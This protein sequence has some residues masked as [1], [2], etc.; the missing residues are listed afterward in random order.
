MVEIDYSKFGRA[1][2][3]L[4]E[5]LDAHL[6]E[7]KNEFIR[8]SVIQRFEFT[9]ELC[10]VTLTRFLENVA[11]SPP[12][13]DMT[14]PAMIR[15]ASELGLLHNGWDVWKEYREARNLTSLTYEESKA[16]QVVGRVPGF[17]ADA[18]YLFAKMTAGED[19]PGERNK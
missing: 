16:M 13:H 2:A 19:G 18:E 12:K 17:Y 6:A 7:P 15:T 11:P 5:A 4:K 8:D 9:F 10:T 3:R 14:Y 1:L